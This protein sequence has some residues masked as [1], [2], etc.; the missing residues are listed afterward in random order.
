ME[1][2]NQVMRDSYFKHKRCEYKAGTEDWS[3]HQEEA[4]DFIFIC[5]LV[6]ESNGK[7]KK[8]KCTSIIQN[9]E[10]KYYYVKNWLLI[11]GCSGL[12]NRKLRKEVAILQNETCWNLICTCREL[13][14]WY[15]LGQTLHDADGVFHIVL[16]DVVR[17][18]KVNWKDLVDDLADE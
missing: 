6:F 18:G 14:G 12:F 11:H 4:W 3:T 10:F 9:P 15:S 17:D 8:H 16:K 7:L 2:Q 1:S 5:D 13:P